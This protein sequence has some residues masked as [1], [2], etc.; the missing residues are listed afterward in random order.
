MYDTPEN[1]TYESKSQK[2]YMSMVPMSSNAE[3]PRRNYGDTSELTDWVLDPSATCYMT[4]EI[5]DFIPGSLTETDKY[6]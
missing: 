4:P 1:I 5:S 3:S 6:I 2:M